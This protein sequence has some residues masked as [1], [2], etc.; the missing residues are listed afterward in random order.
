MPFQSWENDSCAS[1]LSLKTP[2]FSH[3]DYHQ[4]SRSTWCTWG[5]AATQCR[6]L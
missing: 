3:P 1:P 4:A 2:Y 6:R 5:L